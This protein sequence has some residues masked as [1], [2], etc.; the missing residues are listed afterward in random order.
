MQLVPYTGGSMPQAIP[1]HY[2]ASQSEAFDGAQMIMI[3]LHPANVEAFIDLVEGWFAAREEV[4]FV[5]QGTT[6]KTDT[7]FVVMVWD[8]YR[9]DRLFLDILQTTEAVLDYVV[10][11]QE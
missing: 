8:G 3:H 5:D 4:T 9:V 2:E 6:D 1:E 7:G 10:F 11:Y